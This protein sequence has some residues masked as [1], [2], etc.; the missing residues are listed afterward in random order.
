MQKNSVLCAVDVHDF[1]QNVVDIAAHFARQF[2]AEL[3][4]LH[5]TLSPDPTNAAWPAYLGAPNELIRDNRLLRAIETNV[6]G[7]NV[8]SHQLI[9]LPVAKVVEFVNRNEPQLLVLGTHVRSGMKRLLGSIS[10]KILRRVSCPVMLVKQ[11][12]N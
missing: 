7:I 11:A 6:D 8:N 1:D 9:G 2:E 3:H 12:S 4:V 10:A 5:V